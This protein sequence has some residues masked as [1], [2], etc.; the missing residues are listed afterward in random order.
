MGS[1]SA[2]DGTDGPQPE[3]EPPV[4]NAEWEIR[5]G[6]AIDVLTETL[7][8]FFSYG[9]A[10]SID[11]ATGMPRPASSMHIP[12]AGANPL[13]FRHNNNEVETIYSPKVRLSYTPP[14][15]LPAPFPKTLHVEGLPLYFASSVFIRHTLNALY[16]GL[17]VS[18]RKVI[19]QTPGSSKAIVGAVGGEHEGAIAPNP[20]KNTREKSLFVGLTVN[21]TARVSGSVGEWDVN[22]IYTFSPIT[23]LIH[24]HTITSIEPEPHQAVYDTLRSS[25]GKVFGFGIMGDNGDPRPGGAGVRAQAGRGQ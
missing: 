14:V 5:T 15:A 25:L 4:S 10:S 9:L 3:N 8:H 19:V 1:G 20:A 17:H 18:L 6:R 7:P 21:G 16:S 24:V 11:K 22:S 12:I 23:G 2:R 13:D